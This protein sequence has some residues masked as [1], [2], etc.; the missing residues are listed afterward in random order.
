MS[1]MSRFLNIC[2]I[3]GLVASSGVADMAA[4]APTPAGWVRIITDQSNQTWYVDS[5]SLQTRGSIR[6]F[7]SYV[8]GGAPYPNESG[9]LVYGA[10][11]YLSADCKTNSYRLRFTRLLDESNKT[12]QEYNYGATRPM[13]QAVPGS[14]EEASMKFACSRQR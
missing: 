9:R 4:A 11:F 12:V 8:V 5:G 6:Y 7:W 14:G 13:G 10:A 3:A 2:W 1:P